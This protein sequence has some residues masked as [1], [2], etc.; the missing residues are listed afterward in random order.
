MLHNG[1]VMDAEPARARDANARHIVPLRLL[2]PLA[3][4]LARTEAPTDV[5]N[6]HVRAYER[7]R[8]VPNLVGPTPTERPEPSG[9]VGSKASRGGSGSAFRK[10]IL[11]AMSADPMRAPRGRPPVFTDDVLRRAAGYS[12]ARRV[13]TRRGEQD[14]VYRMFAVAVIDHYCEAFPESRSTLAWLL[15][16]RLRHTLLSELGR[17]AR[18]RSAGGGDLQWDEQDVSVLIRVALELAAKKPATKEG[19]ELVRM[20]RRELGG[21]FRKI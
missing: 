10:P 12:Y 21:G 20:R 13:G 19:V 7:S 6:G 4:R 11:T 17:A 16:P 3:G 15:E 5:G 1:A 8:R 14:L 2:R 18:P 9:V